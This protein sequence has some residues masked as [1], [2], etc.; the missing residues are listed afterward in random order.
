MASPIKSKVSDPL[1]NTIV[2]TTAIPDQ[3]KIIFKDS[4]TAWLIASFLDMQSLSVYRCTLKEEVGSYWGLYYQIESRKSLTLSEIVVYQKALRAILRSDFDILKLFNKFSNLTLESGDISSID[5][6]TSLL[7]LVKHTDQLTDD[8]AKELWKNVK[9]STLFECFKEDLITNKQLKNLSEKKHLEYYFEFGAAEAALLQNELTV[10]VQ[11]LS[12]SLTIEGSG[13]EYNY[14]FTIIQMFE[15]STWLKIDLKDNTHTTPIKIVADLLLAVWLKQGQAKPPILVEICLKILNRYDLKSLPSSLSPLYECYMYSEKYYSIRPREAAVVIVSFFKDRVQRLQGKDEIEQLLTSS[16]RLS[17]PDHNGLESRC[18]FKMAFLELFRE[19]PEL[20]QLAQIANFVMHSDFSHG[21]SYPFEQADAAVMDLF[22]R[23]AA[24]N[25]SSEQDQFSIRDRFEQFFPDYQPHLRDSDTAD[26]IAFSTDLS[27]RMKKPF[28]TDEIVTFLSSERAEIS[29]Q[30]LSF[31]REHM[32]HDLLYQ[33]AQKK[34]DNL[35]KLCRLAEDS[36]ITLTV[37][38]EF[39][40]IDFLKEALTLT[41]PQLQPHKQERLSQLDVFHGQITAL[42]NS[43]QIKPNSYCIPSQALFLTALE[44]VR[45]GFHSDTLFDFLKERP[46]L[47]RKHGAGD[48]FIKHQRLLA[49]KYKMNLFNLPEDPQHFQLIKEQAQQLCQAIAN[50]KHYFAPHPV[51]DNIS[52]GIYGGCCAG[53]TL[54]TGKELLKSWERDDFENHLFNLLSKYE[55][56]AT[57]EAFI[58]QVAH[59]ALLPNI[60]KYDSSLRKLLQ[61][62]ANP[63]VQAAAIYSITNS[64]GIDK[65]KTAT[66]LQANAIDPDVQAPVDDPRVQ[67]LLRTYSFFKALNERST[68]SDL[69]KHIF[70]KL[71]AWAENF[72]EEIWNK[73]LNITKLE[74]NKAF[75]SVLGLEL[76]EFIGVKEDVDDLRLRSWADNAPEGVYQ[77]EVRLD[78]GGAGHAVNIMKRKGKFYFTDP[79]TISS[80]EEQ[81]V[82]KNLE[83]FITFTQTGLEMYAVASDTHS[84]RFFKIDQA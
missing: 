46:Q 74:N 52:L 29:Q 22:F 48:L 3:K 77:M 23:E 17:I 33:L 1:L 15:A 4:K 11:Q 14:S 75:Y 80:K 32:N 10:A 49:S 57:Q 72:N 2:N 62:E 44:A 38:Q 30:Q 71:K 56:G 60:T 81:H 64:D 65:L 51:F 25:Y 59:T 78:P 40:W 34:L 13:T 66:F 63:S 19:S 12:D 53:V 21:F 61:L 28:S 79:N 41:L 27:S 55:Q 36:K 16:K 31:F 8:V 35:C 73:K 42:G 9:F 5:S 82:G 47:I 7:L 69:P 68:P 39:L 50:H 6:K 24:I 43:L 58:T 20:P 84:L 45:Q 70:D 83:D 18:I 67:D 37:Q 26:A 54:Q 76:N